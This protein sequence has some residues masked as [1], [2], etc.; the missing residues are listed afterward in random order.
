MWAVWSSLQSTP[1]LA[2]CERVSR[3]PC[4]LASWALA[5]P[6]PCS[7]WPSR[8][9]RALWAEGLGPEPAR[10]GFYRDVGL[11]SGVALLHKV[12]PWGLWGLETLLP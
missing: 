12:N 11:R 6:H 7:S 10:G 4:A 1:M 5:H 9:C 8:P 2:P 3:L